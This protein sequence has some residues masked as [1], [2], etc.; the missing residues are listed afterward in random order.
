MLNSSSIYDGTAYSPYSSAI[1][2]SQHSF[3]GR[4]MG[5]KIPGK[6]Q[7]SIDVSNCGPLE[8]GLMLKKS[9]RK[10]FSKFN[11]DQ[12]GKSKLLKGYKGLIKKI[13]TYTKCLLYVIS[14]K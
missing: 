8:H 6:R 1:S 2:G 3:Y 13:T 12:Q 5:S 9:D 4:P 10:K 14:I 7:M 11:F